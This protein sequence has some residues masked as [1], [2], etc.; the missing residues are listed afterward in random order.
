[1]KDNCFD[2]VV[3]GGGA[4]GV[5][6]AVRSAQLGA[7]VAVVEGQDLG[8]L[9]M[10]R[11]CIPFGQMMAASRII[12]NLVLGKDMGIECSESSIDFTK[13]L[14]RQND[15]IGYMRQ[16]VQSILMKNQVTVIPGMGRLC[17]PG[18]VEVKAE[19]LTADKIIIAVG[20]RWV[21][22]KFP[23]NDLPGVVTSDYLLTGEKL[24][25]KVL[26]Q[27]GGPMALGI[28]QSLRRFGAEVWLIT[29]EKSLLEDENRA[30]RTRLTKVMQADGITVL[31]Q[32]KIVALKRDKNC[33]EAFLLVKEK[34]ETI[35]VDLTVSL[36]RKANLLELG[37]E[38]VGLDETA[39][40]I[41][42][43]ERMETGSEGVYAIGD[44]AAPE[45]S[46]YSSLASSGGIV[47]AENAMGMDSTVDR[48]TVARIVFT[49][50]QM[51]CVGLTSRQAKKAG[52]D[53]VQGS[54]PL[55]MNPYGMIISQQ[56]GIV[57][58][59]A[60]KKYG[61]ILGLHVVGDGAC[62][63][64]GGGVFALQMEAT[65]EELAKASFPHPTLSES[66]AEAARD[67]LGRAIYLP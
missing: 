47:A 2:I 53:V 56:E 14:K 40:Y 31:N 30:I 10:N 38:T 61:E 42:V 28:A 51:A 29:K 59:V 24:P 18:K 36:R 17:G 26:L 15:L 3:I 37:L 32:A 4:G 65:L 23:G 25:Q 12:G 8:G 57:E 41:K 52:Y 55:S 22:P 49:Q 58:V 44:V 16:G 7:K 34:E 45:N 13:L 67:A 1:M 20:S 50:P 6:A 39:E 5:A 21:K 54:A 62:E 43:N 63:I 27:G 66:M 60:E 19:K 9:C 35:S 64:I 48:R 33:L 46:H 11:G